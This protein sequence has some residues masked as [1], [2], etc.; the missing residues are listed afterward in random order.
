MAHGIKLKGL[1]DKGCPVFACGADVKNRFSLFEGGRLHYSGENGDLSNPDSYAR[2]LR[3]VEEMTANARIFPKLVAH[4]LHPMYL[5]SRP[6]H[7]FDGVSR[8]GVQHHHA[9][10]ASVMAQFELERPVIG[11]SFDGT[12]YGTDG[13][14]WGGE[15]LVVSRTG[16]SRRAHFEY[17]KMPGGEAAVREP[18]RMIFGMMYEH[19]GDEIFEMRFDFLRGKTK[20][21]LEF[22]KRAIDKGINVPLTSSCGRLFDAVSSLLGFVQ[23]AGYEAEAAIKLEER[24][25]QTEESGSYDFDIQGKDVYVIGFGE[26][27]DG[28]VC[29]MAAQVP[30][31]RIARKFHNSIARLVVEIARRLQS[32]LGLDTIVLSGGVFQN[33]LLYENVSRLLREGG[34]TLLESRDVPLN[35]LGICVG[36]TFVALNGV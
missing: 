23:V 9:H 16:F 34:F 31:E 20:Q 19:L 35:D 4:D 24:A 33:R 7:M 26:M 1:I 12:G 25:S 28:L 18:W 32:E 15:F 8:M 13:N 11:V 2:F 30:P 14:L 10:V 3:S 36:Q 22:L 17:M 6:M 5:S 29:D 21:E 27:L